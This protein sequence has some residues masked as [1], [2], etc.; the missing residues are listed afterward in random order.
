LSVAAL[1]GIVNDIA[2]AVKIKARPRRPVSFL[3]K[4]FYI[5]LL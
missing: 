2:A 3:S 4:T 1:A 5:I